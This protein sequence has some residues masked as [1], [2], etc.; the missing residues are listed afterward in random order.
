MELR[1]GPLVVLVG[2]NA[3][4]KS[5][6]FD[7][8]RLLAGFVNERTLEATFEG[9]RGTPIESFHRAGR[10]SEEMLRERALRLCLEADVELSAPTVARVTDQVRAS[11]ERVA[12]GSVISHRLLRYGVDVE[13][14]PATGRLRVRGESLE[15]LRRDATPKASRKPFLGRD[16][17]KLH[18]RR[19]GGGHP[20]YHELGL[21]HTVLSEPLYPPHFAHAVAFKEEL[22][23]WR[24]HALT[25]ADMRWAGTVS[26]GEAVG[27][28]GA[29]LATFLGRLGAEHPTELSRLTSRL[30]ELV[31]SVDGL[32]VE[33]D[34]EGAML[35][36]IVEQGVPL[37]ARVAS[38]GT[39]RM[40][41]VLSA[42]SPMSGAT[43]VTLEEPERSV[44]ARRLGALVEVLA[45][46]SAGG[47]LQVVISTHSAAF[48]THFPDNAILVCDKEGW[49]T[50]FEPFGGSVGQL[51]REAAIEEV[52]DV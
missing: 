6:L 20:Y 18:L 42:V 30:R 37:S 22:A 9:H 26:G 39:L 12:S 13:L 48:A 38:S 50:R 35:L 32:Q 19:E 10:T 28:T 11:S 25:T 14:A 23:R 3:S 24:G 8:L 49:E 47:G 31:P 4:G 43:L 46:A 21:D 29:G 40:L 7:A 36:R 16:G 45:E 15:A 52:V 17:S 44:H 5:N 34:A 51:F 2:P 41:G 1:L 33:A 27:R